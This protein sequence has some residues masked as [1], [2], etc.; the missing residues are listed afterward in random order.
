MP[1]DTTQPKTQP[2]QVLTEFEVI[3]R[4]VVKAKTLD[5]AYDMVD[6]NDFQYEGIDKYNLTINPNF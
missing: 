6:N 3:E 1:K 5:E 4:Y 2:K